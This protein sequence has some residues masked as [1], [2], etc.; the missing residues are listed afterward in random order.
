MFDVLETPVSRKTSKPHRLF[1]GHK[2]G[3]VLTPPTMT[4]FDFSTMSREDAKGVT[5]PY[6]SCD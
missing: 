1:E 5:H 4:A 2:D 6:L 3:R